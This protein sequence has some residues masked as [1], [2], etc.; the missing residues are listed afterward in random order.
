MTSK[1]Q[2]AADSQRKGAGLPTYSELAELILRLNNWESQMGGWESPVWL[3]V[4]QVA[5]KLEYLPAETA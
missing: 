2:Q 5:A 4:R 1:I 3:E